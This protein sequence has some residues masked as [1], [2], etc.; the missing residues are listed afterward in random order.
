MN[1]FVQS[2]LQ[3]SYG[4]LVSHKIDSNFVCAIPDGTP[5]FL[6]FTNKLYNKP[7]CFMFEHDE[8]RYICVESTIQVPVGIHSDLVKGT[9]TMICGTRYI[10]PSNGRTY[11]A[12]ETVTNY[13]GNNTLH[14]CWGEKFK[15]LDKMLN[16]KLDQTWAKTTH[17]SF[18]IIGLPLICKTLVE[19]KHKIA[20][21]LVGIQ[22]K[23]IAMINMHTSTFEKVAHNN[24]EYENISPTLNPIE[25]HQHTT[26]F[27]KI[28][29]S[30]QTVSNSQTFLVKPTHMS[31][32]YHLFAYNKTTNAPEYCGI[33]GIPNLKTSK[34]VNKIF[35]PEN[36]ED[37]DEDYD[38]ECDL[39]EQKPYA[40]IVCTYNNEFKKWYPEYESL[41]N[42]IVDFNIAK[43]VQTQC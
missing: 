21:G 33:A 20:D 30:H 2:Y 39:P 1:S 23:Y 35:N 42:N 19:L 36:N 3:V 17:P 13:C 18:M 8:N 32:I 9:G 40:N 26:I 16:L 5:S 10:L 11:F 24:L 12:I 28:S 6:W 4:T 27:E 7:A 22:V 41:T 15:I 29:Q 43:L 34:L 38:D 37:E 25:Q 31:D 14:L